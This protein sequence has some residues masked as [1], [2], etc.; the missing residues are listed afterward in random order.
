[1]EEEKSRKLKEHEK[2]LL[3]KRRNSVRMAWSNIK[4]DHSRWSILLKEKQKL[5][6]E[7]ESRIM[8]ILELQSIGWRYYEKPDLTER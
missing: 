3:Q 8:D 6:R 5:P 4:S 2:V 7:I 1:M